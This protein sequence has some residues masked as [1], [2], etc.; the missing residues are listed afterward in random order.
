M[1][2]PPC[3]F[4][5]LRTFRISE[6]GPY[7]IGNLP[8]WRSVAPSECVRKTGFFR[9]R[10]LPDW[11][12]YGIG[13]LPVW[14][15][16]APSERVRKRGP[17]RNRILP[18]WRN[19]AHRVRSKTR[20]HTDWQLRTLPDWDPFGL[21]KW[22]ALRVRSNNKDPSGLAEGSLP[23]CELSKLAMVRSKN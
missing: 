14:R 7:G 13:N 17:F 11:G 2:T 16:V 20:T 18:D 3:T 23:D 21:T 12:P 15:G 6:K 4:E 19:G 5:I 8:V 1:R 10:I 9:I 22:G